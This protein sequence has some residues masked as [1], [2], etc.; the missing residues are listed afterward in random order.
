M[1]TCVVTLSGHLS[2]S[3]SEIVSVQSKLHWCVG[4][5]TNLN[6]L[7]FYSAVKTKGGRVNDRLN[8]AHTT[9]MATL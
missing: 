9:L 7:E 8:K 5:D 4:R 1:Y 2:Q 6:V 3:A